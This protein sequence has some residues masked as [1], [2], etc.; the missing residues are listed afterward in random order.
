[1]EFL[2]GDFGTK[3]FREL[4]VMAAANQNF[5][6]GHIESTQMQAYF[7]NNS[8]L[9]PIDCATRN[10]VKYDYIGSAPAPRFWIF[11]TQPIAPDFLGEESQANLDKG[12]REVQFIPRDGDKGTRQP[13]GLNLL[14]KNLKDLL[15]Y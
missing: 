2:S 7:V 11:T 6:F 1:V 13:T 8:V 12:L 15:L 9:L 5:D 10:Q 14:P 3:C 4:E